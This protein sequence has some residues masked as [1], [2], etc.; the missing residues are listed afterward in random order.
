MSE[1]LATLETAALELTPRER[2]QLA[3]RLLASVGTDGDVEAAWAEEIEGRLLDVE[4]GTVEL[5]LLET[6]LNRARQALA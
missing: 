2:V 4:G 5:V 6:A 3:D 1:S